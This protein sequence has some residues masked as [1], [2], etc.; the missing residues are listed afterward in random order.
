MNTLIQLGIL[1]RCIGEIQGRKKLQKIVH[2]LQSFGVPFDVRFGYHYFGPYSDEL[3]DS[4]QACLH[5][6]LLKETPIPGQFPTSKFLPQSKLIEMLE[7][8]QAP[9][10]PEWLEFAKDLNQKSPREL[11]AISTLIYLEHDQERGR[12]HEPVE[13]AF[14]GL[15]P[16]LTSLL[17]QATNNLESYRSKYRFTKAE[18]A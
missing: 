9:L 5:D 18:A 11:E 13:Q 12:L 1:L 16:Q 2:I 14:V 7:K 4:V 8:T 15:K 3:Q 10:Q 6:G 17:P